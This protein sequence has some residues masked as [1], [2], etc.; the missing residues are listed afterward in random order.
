ME[1]CTTFNAL[2]NSNHNRK[3]V[4]TNGCKTEKDTFFSS[5][6]SI[7]GVSEKKA[8]GITSLYGDAIA[9][10]GK[11]VS[12]SEEEGKRLLQDIYTFGGNQRLGPKLSAKIYDIFYG[13][14]DG[15]KIYT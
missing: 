14:T 1:K 13:N 4:R 3:G 10:I 11:Y 5:L 7:N 8:A 2:T 9:L 6:V 15:D 12:L